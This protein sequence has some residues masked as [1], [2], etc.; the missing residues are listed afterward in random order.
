MEPAGFPRKT[1]FAVKLPRDGRGL[2]GE[3][4]AKAEEVGAALGEVEAETA[5]VWRGGLLGE[6]ADC[7]GAGGCPIEGDWDGLQD[8]RDVEGAAGEGGLD[9]EAVG[10]EAH[11]G[12]VEVGLGGG[13]GLGG[14]V[15]A[16]GGGDVQS[17]EE[18]GTVG[19]V[20][21]GEAEFGDAG[22]GRGEFVGE[23]CG[24]VEGLRGGAF[25]QPE[26]GVRE[27]VMVPWGPSVGAPEV[28]LW[29]RLPM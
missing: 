28:V 5:D 17:V 2:G 27:G 24:Q 14:A 9:P 29:L 18:A 6:G 12:D 10:I 21:R 4:G 19:V 16:D 26:V 11:R 7:G 8:G 20:V 23:A 1:V 3:G 22:L 13:E 15:C 25:V